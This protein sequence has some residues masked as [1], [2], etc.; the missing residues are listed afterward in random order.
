MFLICIVKLEMAGPNL[1]WNNT[2]TSWVG[3]TKTAAAEEHA[4]AVWRQVETAL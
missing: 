4:A 3:V 2:Q 1:N